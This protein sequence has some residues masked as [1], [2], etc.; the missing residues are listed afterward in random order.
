MAQEPLPV[1]VVIPA[2]RRPD[3]VE[4]AIRS[5][6]RQHRT[7]AEILVVDDCSGDETGARATSLGARVIT[8]EQNLGEGGARNT[9]LAKASHDWVALLDSDDEWL[10]CHLETVWNAR[11]GHVLVGSAALVT[12]HV[13]AR[14][15]Y[16]W[17]GTRPFVL[18]GPA[19]VAVPENKLQPSAVL[20]LRQSALDLG[21]F[22][23]GMPR[24]ADLD[25]WVRMLERGTGLAIP[26]VTALYHVHPE[27]VS[28]DAAPMRAAYKA[29]I[30]TY[31]NRPWCNRVVRDR[32]AGV[33]AWDDAR[34]AWA[35]GAPAAA[36]GFSLARRLATPQ[37]LAGLA[38]LLTGRLRSRRL[39]ARFTASGEPSSA[40]L[41]GVDVDPLPNSAIDLR[42]DSRL[43]AVAQLVRRPPARILVRGHVDALLARALGSEPVWPPYD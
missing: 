42:R 32:Q 35:Q 28:I 27:Q 13:P 11:N 10:P 40:I 5:V 4:R 17:S 15:V 12:G 20:L 24:A 2:Y 30:E 23:T 6:L 39:A 21:G 18:R 29:V 19:D 1:T 38:L 33:L 36:T 16:G 26:R 43:R 41:P 8:H 34:A 25:M 14:R 37:R 3:M 9:G 31:A 22:R 7:A